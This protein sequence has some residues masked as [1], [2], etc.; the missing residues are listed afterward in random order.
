MEIDIPEKVA[1]YRARNNNNNNCS[2]HKD[3]LNLVLVHRSVYL[4]ADCCGGKHKSCL[5]WIS[6]GNIHKLACKSIANK[7]IGLS[8]CTWPTEK[9]LS[10]LSDLFRLILL[11]CKFSLALLLAFGLHFRFRSFGGNYL[12]AIVYKL[13]ILWKCIS[14]IC[15]GNC[16]PL[17]PIPFPYHPISS[18][19][20]LQTNV[21]KGSAKLTESQFICIVC[22][23][24][25]MEGLLYISSISQQQQQQSRRCH[26]EEVE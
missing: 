19:R 17:V 13:Y 15:I 20:T 1:N 22:A 8:V 9:R 3:S 24:N 12:F 21:D 5:I 25:R 23:G 26:E 16:R 11:F 4:L 2:L 14:R 7:E 6:P 10:G 18:T